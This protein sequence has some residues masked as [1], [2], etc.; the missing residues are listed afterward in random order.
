MILQ[1]NYVTKKE[2]SVISG[3]V[4]MQN[5]GGQL[6]GG[7]VQDHLQLDAHNKSGNV[8]R[9]VQRTFQTLTTT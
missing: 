4:H 8:L 1:C 5:N 2:Q 6:R 3:H 7:A 9:N